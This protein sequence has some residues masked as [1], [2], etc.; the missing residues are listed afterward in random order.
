[1]C[2]D[3]I[4]LYVFFFMEK[5]KIDCVSWLVLFNC[6]ELNTVKMI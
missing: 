4:W 5:V 2:Y 1:M 6:I 3:E